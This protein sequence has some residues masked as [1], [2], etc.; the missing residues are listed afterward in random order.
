MTYD[1]WCI[2]LKCKV[3]GTWNLHSLLP[4]GMDFFIMYSSIAGGIGGTAS[5]SY[6]AGCTYQDALAHYR[7]S[8]NEKATTFNLGVMMDDGYIHISPLCAFFNATNIIHSVLRDNDA[9]RNALLGTGYLTGVKQADLF[10]LLEYHCDPLLQ[11]PTRPLESQVLIGV[12][13]P[14]AI[15]ARGGEIP[16]MMKRPHFRATWN[17]S[18]SR[19]EID[20][21]ETTA[22]DVAQ[23]LTKAKSLQCAGEI[24]SKAL[25]ERL[26]SALGVP[27]ESLDSSKPLHAYGVDSLVAVELRNWC[28]Q[29][30]DADI[31]VFEILGEATFQDIGI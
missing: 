15:L 4:E 25:I 13:F 27:I 8:I 23:E 30:L 24:I 17:V 6:S 21:S 16:T 5:V 12:D 26:S 7:N 3:P 22:T 14:Q 31:A 28:K 10:A 20:D 18:N 29:K 19:P 11:I 2:P 9:V 1:D